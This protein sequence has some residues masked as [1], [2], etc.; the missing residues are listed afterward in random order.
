MKGNYQDPLISGG[1]F[2]TDPTEYLWN[3]AR[4]IKETAGKYY[5]GYET[6][7]QLPEANNDTKVEVVDLEHA[8]KVLKDY[9]EKLN[10]KNKNLVLQVSIEELELTDSL[11]QEL[12]QTVSDP[13]DRFQI[14]DLF[15]IS[16][17]IHDEDTH[18][19]VAHLS[20][21]DYAMKFQ[22]PVPETSLSE[23]FKQT[24]YVLRKHENKITILDTML[25]DDG[26]FLTFE[27]DQFSTYALVSVE[28]KLEEDKKEDILDIENPKTNDSIFHSI[29][30]L[31]MSFSVFIIT[32]FKKN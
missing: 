20:K 14:L 17:Q 21:L 3:N 25:S 6:T 1:I 12:Q 5:V 8:T 24:Y 32:L 7:V 30:L 10:I 23:D 2:D 26:K 31:G 16:I 29:F 28:Q 13:F 18:D 9:S 15:D 4:I 11:E 27:S 19:V 22:I